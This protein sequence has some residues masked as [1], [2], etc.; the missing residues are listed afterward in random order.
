MGR[1]FL[2]ERCKRFGPHQRSIASEHQHRPVVSGQVIAAHHHGM[3]GPLLFSLQRELDTARSVYASFLQRA[4]ETGEQASIDTTNARVIPR[5]LPPLQ[6]SW[7]PLSLLV[8]GAGYGV[9]HYLPRQ[10]EEMS[11][12]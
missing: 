8:V 2:Q 6:R 11:R 12:L 9:W 5:A 10:Q 7:P 4:R 1:E 3:P